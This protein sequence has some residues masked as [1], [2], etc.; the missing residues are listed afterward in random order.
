M[1]YENI[2][3]AIANTKLRGVKGTTGTQ[4]SFLQLF[5]GNHEKVKKLNELVVKK[6][7]FDKS[8]A[9]SGQTYS[10]KY[11]YNI[12]SALSQIAQSA[13][14]FANDIRILQNMKEIMM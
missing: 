5:D 7:G 11:D 4:A 1:D 6:M 3:F 13:Y 10:R 9:V 2:E 8:F 12:L 14:K